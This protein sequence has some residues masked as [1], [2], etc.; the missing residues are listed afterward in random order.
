M[1][2][3][4]RAA[5]SVFQVRRKSLDGI[6]FFWRRI[7]YSTENVAEQLAFIGVNRASGIVAQFLQLADVMKPAPRQQE[8]GIGLRDSG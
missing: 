4:H 3:E 1:A 2:D 7:H 8:I 5:P 6:N